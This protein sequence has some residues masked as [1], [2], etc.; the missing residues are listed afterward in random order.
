MALRLALTSVTRGGRWFA[1]QL[2]VSVAA[3]LC[4][5]ALFP[6]GKTPGE[7]AASVSNVIDSGKS[8]QR[9]PNAAT[10]HTILHFD[11]Q[12]QAARAS[13]ASF[14]PQAGP[15][16]LVQITAVSP[17]PAP[18]RPPVTALPP[19]RPVLTVT[20]ATD[21]PV[22]PATARASE[23]WRVAGVGI[24]G[25]GLVRRYVPSASDI[26][27]TGSGAWTATASATKTVARKVV[28]LGGWFGL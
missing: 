10:D 12:Q 9:I 16:P 14:T 28:D 26:A 23:N 2:A 7:G 25:S 20:A 18:A 3:A 15:A 4:V 19:R 22:P 27:A 1:T 8:A 5:A 21:A 24:P 13:F 6:S 11:S 17:R